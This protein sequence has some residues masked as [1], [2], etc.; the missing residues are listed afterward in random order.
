[1]QGQQPLVRRHTGLI[2]LPELW[3]LLFAK[4]FLYV[5]RI[6]GRATVR[7]FEHFGDRFDTP[8]TYQPAAL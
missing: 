6:Q 1:M 7:F 8:L 4:A 3:Q 5:P 2:P